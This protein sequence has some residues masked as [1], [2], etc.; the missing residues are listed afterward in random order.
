[1]KKIFISEDDPL[2]VRM[3]EKIFKLSGYEV[4]MAFNGE[5]ALAKLKAAPGK[6]TVILLD[7]M[8]PK[9]NGLDVLKAIKEIP[10][11]KKIPVIMLT[12]L[13][14]AADAEKALGFGA[15]LYLVKSEYEPKQVV[16]K[17]KEIISGYSRQEDIPEAK[18]AVKDIEQ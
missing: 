4:E 13:A 18:V 10:D 3:Y 9:L 5:E 16:E 17:V 7:I 1:M 6:P 12:N 14:G 2:M 15:V 11:L 8:M